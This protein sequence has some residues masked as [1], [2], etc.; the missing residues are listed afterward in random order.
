MK[1][2]RILIFLLMLPVISFGALASL[3]PS[4]GAPFHTN[5]LIF[6]SSMLLGTVILLAREFRRPRA[7]DEPKQPG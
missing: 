4:E 7:N 5:W 2:V 3:E 6:Y 1:I